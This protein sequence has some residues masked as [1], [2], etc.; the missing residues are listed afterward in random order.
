MPC[1]GAIAKA[2][3]LPHV[4]H[5]T[6]LRKI[7]DMCRPT[8]GSITPLLK[9]AEDIEDGLDNNLPFWGPQNFLV[10]HYVIIY[11]IQDVRDLLER[12]SNNRA[13]D[14]PIDFAGNI[15]RFMSTA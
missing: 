11:A 6:S 12:W 5:G 4:K 13:A 10:F 3:T 15:D 1:L 2:N 7:N 8:P 9:L 14:G